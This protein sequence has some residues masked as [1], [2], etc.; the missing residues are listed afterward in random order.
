MA[1][2]LE[3]ILND[4]ID[5]L[6]RGESL[7]QCLQR[8]PERAAELRPLLQVALAALRASAVEPRAEF[9]AQARYQMRSLLHAR[10]LKRQPKRLPLLRWLPRWAV[11]VIVA[12]FA[13]LVAGTGTVAAASDSLPG[14][15]LYAVKLAT[16]RVQLAFTFSDTGKAKL[17]AKFA[18]RRAEEMARI[19]DRDD[20]EKVEA[21]LSRLEGN[22]SQVEKLTAK[23]GGGEPENES[24]VAGLRRYLQRR[25]ARDLEVLEAV[26]GVTPDQARP[27]I[28]AAKAKLL[29]D[30]LAALDALESQG[31]GTT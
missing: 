1:E 10:E 12:I 27:A 30:Y 23:I 15:T 2:E 31:D 21:L 28:T 9:K 24:Q 4:C 20:P 8:Y 22:L 16:E 29:Q 7:E 3:S 25:A 11:I 19:A 14:D 6:L 26:E 5:R 13:F 17:E 18:G